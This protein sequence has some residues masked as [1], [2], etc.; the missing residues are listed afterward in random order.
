MEKYNKV[1]GNCGED[2]AVKYLK[3]NKYIVTERNFNVRGGEIDIIA[4]K[5]G[6]VIFVEVKTRTS[7][8]WGNP[9]DFI[10]KTKIKRIVE[11]ADLYLQLNNIDK[12]ARFDII[13]AVWDGEVF[14]IEHIDDAFM[15]PVF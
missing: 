7:R 9:E 15:S 13:S 8:Q 2:A 11:A 1:L 10:G 14:D 5:G 6:Y 4:K 3:K 12:P